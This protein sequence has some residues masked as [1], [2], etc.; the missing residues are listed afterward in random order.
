MIYAYKD[1]VYLFIYY[2][3][4]YT[5][6]QYWLMERYTHTVTDRV[7]FLNTWYTDSLRCGHKKQS[8]GYFKQPLPHAICLSSSFYGNKAN[9]IIAKNHFI[10]CFNLTLVLII[11]NK[12]QCLMQLQKIYS[13]TKKNN[14]CKKIY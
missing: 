6:I 14:P 13:S 2:R 3:D 10:S 4:Y 11:W 12:L 1:V 5:C 9:Q 8:A 7:T